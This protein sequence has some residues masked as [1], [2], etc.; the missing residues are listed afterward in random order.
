[1]QCTHDEMVM[2][3]L[4]QR[5]W[6]VNRRPHTAQWTHQ[7]VGQTGLTLMLTLMS[8]VMVTMMMTLRCSLLRR[9]FQPPVHHPL[10]LLLLRRRLPRVR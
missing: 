2:S 9:P 4:T 8:M 3:M 6:Q 10:L 1:M 5:L 7:Q